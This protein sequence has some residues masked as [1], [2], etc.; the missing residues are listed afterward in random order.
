MIVNRKNAYKFLVLFL[1]FSV[2]ANTLLAYSELLRIRE[3]DYA[4][5]KTNLLSLSKLLSYPI[6]VGDNVKII[7]LAG[8]INK[9]TR[10]SLFFIEEVDGESLTV[11]NH[12]IEF[13]SCSI[14]KISTNIEYNGKKLGVLSI[15]YFDLPELSYSKINIGSVTILNLLLL[16]LFVILYIYIKEQ[17]AHELEIKTIIRQ[18]AHDIRSPLEVLRSVV[19][20]NHNIEVREKKVMTNSLVRIIDITNSLLSK[21]KSSLVEFY[22]I[23]F[24]IDELINKKK[25]EHK[26]SIDFI[27]NE[28][29]FNS[30]YVYGDDGVAYRALS[31]LI[32]NAIEANLDNKRIKV[33]LTL[34]GNQ[35]SLKIVDHGKGMSEAFLKKAIKGGV[36]TKEDGN[37]LGLSYS[38]KELNIKPNKMYIGSKKGVGTT[39]SIEFERFDISDIYINS[40]SLKK[41]S[42]VLCIDD[43]EAF[44]DVYNTLIGKDHQMQ[45]STSVVDITDNYDL[46]LCDYDLGN[47]KT[48]ID[49]LNNINSRVIFVTSKYNDFKLIDFCKKNNFK[50]VPKQIINFVSV[51]DEMINECVLIDDDKLIHMMWER[52]AGL[53]GVNLHTFLDVDTF[54]D[55]CHDLKRE[56]NIY[57]DSN[58]AHDKKGEDEAE[59][60]FKAGFE[61]IFLVTGLDKRDIQQKRWIKDVFGKRP[62]F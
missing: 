30:F 60:I 44:F 9:L 53:K 40:I 27:F 47:K 13:K 55:S 12:N 29:S 54:L 42:K 7:E 6:K 24:L 8:A 3:I 58:L 15:C 57:I 37:G 41:K 2:I 43:N 56:I 19:N 48:S 38:Y 50:I 35:V 1:L 49:D 59:K 18:I 11:N 52:E 20:N 25:I 39:I 16:L 28:E 17:Q 4:S 61:N 5:K 26:D 10:E 21:N 32:N 33:E 22:N 31:N 36:T 34:K 51:K 62:V 14:N 46:I 23:Y 45:F